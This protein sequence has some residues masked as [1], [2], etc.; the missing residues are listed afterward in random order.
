MSEGGIQDASD[1]ACIV[2]RQAGPD[3]AREEPERDDG[4]APYGGVSAESAVVYDGDPWEGS[5]GGPH[6]AVQILPLHWHGSQCD[7]GGKFKPR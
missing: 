2:E 5:T 3:T 4:D 6:A 7:E 1:G